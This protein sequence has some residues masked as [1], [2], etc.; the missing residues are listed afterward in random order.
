MSEWHKTACNLC[1]VNCALEVQTAGRAITRI[2]GD[3]ENPRT[4][5]YLCQKPQR[6]TWYA[7]CQ[8]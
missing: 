1:Y 3:K 4:A 8:K 5:G 2:R 7:C 6:L